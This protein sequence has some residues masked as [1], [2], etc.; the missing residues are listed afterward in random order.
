MKKS[1]L[2]ILFAFACTTAFAAM[3]SEFVVNSVTAV[4]GTKAAQTAT[5][6]NTTPL[7]IQ[8][9]ASGCTYQ[10]NAAGTTF[11][12]TANTPHKI[13][14]GGSVTSLAFSCASSAGWSVYVAK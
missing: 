5:V 12:I 9:S 2:T 14:P 10:I 7:M 6:T 13:Q 4:S 1:I 11:P 8:T 3:T